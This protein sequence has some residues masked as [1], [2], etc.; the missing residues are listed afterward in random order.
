MAERKYGDAASAYR[1]AIAVEK[2]LPIQIKLH[3][4]LLRSGSATN[5]DALLRTMEKEH[6]DD[7]RF[8]MYS[9]ESLIAQKRWADALTH[10][11]KVIALQPNNA[12]ALN[13]A[14]WALHELKDPKA[15]DLAEKA[16]AA[17]PQAPAILDTLGVVLVSRGETARGIAVLRQAIVLAPKAG[18]LRLHLAEALVKGGDKAGARAELETLMKDAPEGP[19][20]TRAKEILSTL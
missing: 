18:M 17:A 5:A 9:G 10:Y 1:K 11:N 4:A 8:R 7:V 15:L 20:A 3:Q 6:G 19:L 13:N 14:A 2:S 16:A 12:L